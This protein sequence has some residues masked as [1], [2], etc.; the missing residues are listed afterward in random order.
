MN[1]REKERAGKGRKDGRKHPQPKGMFVY[2]LVLLLIIF[3]I[4]SLLSSWL[5]LQCDDDDDDDDVD[6]VLSTRGLPTVAII[7]GA[8]L[9]ENIGG[10]GQ[11]KKLTTSF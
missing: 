7:A 9:E 4:F 11:D 8:V 1:G 5:S 10:E 6:D 3:F 2:S